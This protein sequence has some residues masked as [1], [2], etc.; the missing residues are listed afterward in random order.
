[1]FFWNQPPFGESEVSA[2]HAPFS[3]SRLSAPTKLED[4]MGPAAL[5]VIVMS[6]VTR[7]AADEPAR[8]SARPLVRTHSGAQRPAASVVALI[9]FE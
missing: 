4:A 8:R 1:M 2:A 6:A 5:A 7:R 3:E 9:S